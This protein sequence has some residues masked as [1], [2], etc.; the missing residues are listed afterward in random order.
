MQNWV[1]RRPIEHKR[2]RDISV[3]SCRQVST[4]ASMNGFALGPHTEQFTGPTI[5][6]APLPARMRLTP[7]GLQGFAAKGRKQE[8]NPRGCASYLSLWSMAG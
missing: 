1:K 2:M 4:G 6:L 8:V 7:A 3:I 5:R